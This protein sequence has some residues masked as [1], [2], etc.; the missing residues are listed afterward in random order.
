M[1]TPDEI[2]VPRLTGD[3][4]AS[5][6]H[7]ASAALPRDATS[8]DLSS[9]RNGR[10]LELAA[11]AAVRLVYFRPAGG[12]LRLAYE[13]GLT[14]VDPTQAWTL[15]VDARSGAILSRVS[16]VQS[17]G[18]GIDLRGKRVT[19]QTSKVSGAWKL[20]DRSQYM[21]RHHSNHPY[22]KFEGCIEI[23]DC[24]HL[25]DDEGEGIPKPNFA[26]VKDLNGDNFFNHGGKNPKNNQRAAVSLARSLATTYKAVRTRLGR[27]SL[28][29]AGM[30]VVGNVHLGNEYENAYW[31]SETK[32]MYFGD[33]K[34]GEPP[35]PKSLDVVAHEFGHGITN[36]AVPGDGL[37]YQYPSGA[38][39]ESFSDIWGCT[40]DYGDWVMGEDLGTPVRD[41]ENP[42]A[43]A[44]PLPSNMLEYNLWV[45]YLDGGG[46]HFNCGI[47]GHFFQQ[48]GASLP[49][50][51]PAADGRFTAARIIY[52]SYAHIGNYASMREWAFA[53]RQS[54]V[55][56]YGA[57]S[58]ETI[59][60]EKVLSDLGLSTI[61]FA[62]WDDG[63]CFDDQGNLQGT[64]FG[65]AA[66]GMTY[67]GV[68]YE[69]PPGAMLRRIYVA[70][71]QESVGAKDFYLYV[72][73][74]A[75]NGGID[76]DGDL[77]MEYLSPAN[78]LPSGQ[79][80]PVDITDNSGNPTQINPGSQF[81]L[82]IGYPFEDTA[83]VILLDSG[84]NPQDRGWVL[85]ESGG[86]F[87]TAPFGT[88]TGMTGNLMI[89]PMYCFPSPWS[90]GA[91]ATGG[92]IGVPARPEGGF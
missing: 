49:A 88:A 64:Q 47:G 71:H 26:V 89:R 53:L 68:K 27:N 54:A 30:A 70:L 17:V 5:R 45:L 24:R 52:R 20:I 8:P 79:F 42:G 28:D 23:R 11:P 21:Y 38:L 72:C 87:S 4:A 62:Q 73:S 10:P 50:V 76:P 75:P 13:V 85:S 78:V 67:V 81:F 36:F 57:S 43:V 82:V 39:S 66:N 1:P 18:R 19:L 3:Q 7:A 46:N 22:T 41:L 74:V 31:N 84:Q 69:L 9:P 58:S 80:T 34:P 63:W 91:G 51:P 35:Y 60:T 14:G 16:D 29:G 6:A 92:T 48:L 44:Q 65:Y 15:V 12:G 77:D 2:Q 37:V 61:D 25:V 56:L 90:A 86:A 40:V 33:N 59:A 83:P 32:M 55:E